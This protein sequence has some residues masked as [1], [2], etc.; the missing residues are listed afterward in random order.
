M[1]PSNRRG[2][3]MI[4]VLWVITVMMILVLGLGFESR[5]DV[6]RTILYRDRAK[7]YWLARAAVERVKFDY[8]ESRR[9]GQEDHELKARFRYEFEGGYAECILQSQSS[10]MSANSTNRELWHQLLKLYLPE[11]QARDQ[12]IDAILDWMDPDDLE[13]L[14]GAELEYYQ[15]LTPPYLPRNGPFNSVEEL[16]LVRGITEPMFYGSLH[17]QNGV[18][19]LKD[20]LSVKAQDINRFDVN[21]CP[22]GILMAFLEIDAEQAR[23]VIKARN[24]KLFETMDEV[25][26]L[27]NT[28][29]PGN[30]AKFLF[31]NQKPNQFT[32]KATGFV[33]GSPARYTVEDEVRYTGGAKLFVNLSH[34][35]F[36]LEHVD[37]LGLTEEEE[38]L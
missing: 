1:Y 6:E 7:A 25:T 21:T 3:V 32:I 9:T 8:A 19:G 11:D 36:S 23:E 38:K 27:I 22:L 5:S 20:L 26:A 10:L 31:P 34:K 33:N 18:P 30:A 12:V 29:V 13:Q 16:L 14:N 35:D 4:A 37:D 15:S 17:R 24:E 2:S 28:E